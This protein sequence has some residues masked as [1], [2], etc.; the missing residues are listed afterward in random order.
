[1]ARYEQ[2]VKITEVSREDRN[3]WEIGVPGVY[4]SNFLS[5]KKE[6]QKCTSFLLSVQ[7]LR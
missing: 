7:K 6:Y 1:M 4:K 3:E 2:E 5:R